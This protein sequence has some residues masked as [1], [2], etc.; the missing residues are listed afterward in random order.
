MGPTEEMPSHFKPI[1]VSEFLAML[2]FAGPRAQENPS[3]YSSR[4]Y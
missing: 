1:D 4:K 3:L 2:G